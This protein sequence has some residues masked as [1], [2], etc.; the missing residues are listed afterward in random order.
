MPVSR[1]RKQFKAKARHN[2]R[3]L[4]QTRYSATNKKI[5]AYVQQIQEAAAARN[6]QLKPTEKD[7]HNQQVAEVDLMQYGEA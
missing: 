5:Q 2:R 1:Q 7:F 3:Q 4:E 6:L